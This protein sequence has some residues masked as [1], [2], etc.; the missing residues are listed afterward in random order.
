MKI[1]LNDLGRMLSKCLLDAFPGAK[2]EACNFVIDLTKKFPS[3]LGA[4]SG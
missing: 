3:Y 4:F 2:K 1:C